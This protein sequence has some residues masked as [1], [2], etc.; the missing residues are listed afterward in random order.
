MEWMKRLGMSKPL[1][2]VDMGSRTIKGLRLKKHKGR[3][4][5]DGYFFHDLAQT[6]ESYPERSN[7]QETLKAG[8]EIQKLR[9]QTF[10][11][12]VPD[13]E[14]M[15]VALSLPKLK[16]AEL[17][18]AVKHEL[19]EHTG[20]PI[21]E[22][23]FDFTVQQTQGD[24][25]QESMNVSAYGVRRK[26]IDEL[27]QTMNGA[28][29]RAAVVEPD[30][31]AICAMLE[32]NKYIDQK[33]TYIV[34]DLGERHLTT[35]LVCAGD[36]KLSKSTEQGMGRINAALMEKLRISYGEA[37][38]RKLK[39]DF[40]SSPNAQESAETD[41]IIDESYAAIFSDIK[42]TIELFRQ[43]LPDSSQIK[44]LLLVG[45]GSQTPNLERVFQMF[46]RMPTSVVNPFR[47]IEI[48]GPQASDDKIG[49][50]AP[51]M[52]TA[53]GSALRGCE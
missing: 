19:S 52:A 1:L 21:E 14:V 46:F 39:Y 17:R 41:L 23:A 12:T 34:F 3:V 24:E 18:T 33:D 28:S 42:A 10:A 48:F 13:R 30:T 50:L 53:V 8:I 11:T 6:S 15:H 4:F 29:L 51:F 38:R 27:V 35:T 7:A 43:N 49:E 31:L 20:I 45:G 9:K 44:Q 2:G 16:P 25:Q 37:E 36:I 26:V 32:F 47:N 22:L 40:N 5:L